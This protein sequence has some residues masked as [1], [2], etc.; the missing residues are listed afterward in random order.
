ME[1]NENSSKIEHLDWVLANNNSS[2]RYSNYADIQEVEDEQILSIKVVNEWNYSNAENF[3]LIVKN[4]VEIGFCFSNYTLELHL[5][6][7]DKNIF[8]LFSFVFA[9]CY[10]RYFVF[11]TFTIWNEYEF[12]VASV[13]FVA[14]SFVTKYKI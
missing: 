10:L 5:Y 11:I 9:S 4:A 6:S 2:W 7:R 3:V 8:H 14:C 1:I 12:D 13:F